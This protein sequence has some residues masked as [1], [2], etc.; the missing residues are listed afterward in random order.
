MNNRPIN[1]MR[2][3]HPG[4]ILR[5]DFLIPLNMS[6]NALALALKVP[7]SRIHEIVKERRSVS[8]DTA[9]RL[10]RYFGGDAASW[11]NLQVIYDLKTLSNREEIIQQIQPR[12]SEQIA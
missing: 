3:V 9:A 12:I 11:L 1:Q 8:A 2:P 6:V 4:E 7:A 10:A 5:E